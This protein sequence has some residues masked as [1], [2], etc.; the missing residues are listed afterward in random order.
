MKEMVS[1]N[2]KVLGEKPKAL[3]K[4]GSGTAWGGGGVVRIR[5]HL[6]GTN[7]NAYQKAQSPLCAF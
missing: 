6:L 3:K 1:K 2:Q 7:R 4:M 5:S